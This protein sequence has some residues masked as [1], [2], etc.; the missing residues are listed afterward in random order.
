MQHKTIVKRK[1][2]K[3]TRVMYHA[4]NTRVGISRVRTENL[5]YHTTNL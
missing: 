1:K 5:S 2:K 4:E 3:K